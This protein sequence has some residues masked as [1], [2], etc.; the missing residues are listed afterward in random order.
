VAKAINVVRAG[1]EKH[2][3][4]QDLSTLATALQRDLLMTAVTES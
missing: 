1:A 2:P 3:G 4:D